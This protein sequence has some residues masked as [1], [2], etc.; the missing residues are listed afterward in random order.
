MGGDFFPDTNIK[1]ALKAVSEYPITV[2]LVGNRPL[3]EKSLKKYKQF[4]HKN[5]EIVHAK[6]VIEMTDSPAKAFRSKKKSSIHIG[7]EFVKSGQADAFVSAGNTG[8]VLTATTFILGRIEGIER[9]AL[10]G[11]IPSEKKHFTMLDMGSNV[12]CKPDHLAQFA[13]MGNCFSKEILKTSS[14]RVG[15]LNIGEEREKGN[16][17]TQQSYDLIETLDLN[18]IGNV[19][20]KDLT[21]GKADVVICDG[22]VGNNVLKFGEGIT[23]LFRKFFKEEA[24]RSLISFLGLLLLKPTFKRFK[25]RFDYDEYGG[26]YFLGV[27]GIS[28]IAHGSA[29]EKAI[30]NALKMAYQSVQSSMIDKIKFSL[31]NSNIPLKDKSNS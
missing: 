23:S 3:I 10:A 19:E 27:N 16:M 21:K 28:I 17:L 12:D 2:I 1:G 15:L 31:K 14:P 22:F 7:L 20:G 8:A 30:K 25:K 13:V 6:D 11:I 18:F 4:P 9:P 5:I 26:A 29:S 24:K